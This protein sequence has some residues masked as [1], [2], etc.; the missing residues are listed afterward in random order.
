MNRQDH[1]KLTVTVWS[2]ALQRTLEVDCEPLRWFAVRLGEA[3]YAARH[4]HDPQPPGDARDVAFVLSGPE[5]T[6]VNMHNALA[7]ARERLR[8]EGEAL[9]REREG[10]E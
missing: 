1:L 3:Q 7:C 6:V 9:R 5:T 8:A 10:G 4:G 2:D